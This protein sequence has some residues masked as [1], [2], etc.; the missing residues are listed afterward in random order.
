[1]K[2]TKQRKENWRYFQE[3]YPE[4]REAYE[5]YGR[6]MGESAGPLDSRTCALIKVAVSAASQ[7]D[8]ALRRHIE[9][10]VQSGCTNDEIEHAILQIATTSGFPRMMTA[11]K[12][13][14]EEQA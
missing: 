12:I 13:W 14:R 3:K 6:A 11:L 4:A 9:Q 8:H 2:E 5:A 10:A 1:M 7:Y